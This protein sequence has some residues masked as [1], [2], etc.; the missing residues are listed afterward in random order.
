MCVV[1]F[2]VQTLNSARVNYV[3]CA[4]LLFVSKLFM[5][6]TS[7]RYVRMCARLIAAEC[8]AQCCFVAYCVLI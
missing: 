6:C 5:T 4:V 2:S 7:Y 3:Q 8:I 1:D